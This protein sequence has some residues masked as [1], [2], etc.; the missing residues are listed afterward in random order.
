LRVGDEERI[1]RY[2]EA[3]RLLAWATLR[4]CNTRDSVYSVPNPERTIGGIRFKLTRQWFRVDTIQHVA[5]FY[6]KFLQCFERG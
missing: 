2:H 4:L 6:L 5:C 3:L 1:A